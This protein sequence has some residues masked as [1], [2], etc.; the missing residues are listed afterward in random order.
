MTVMKSHAGIILLVYKLLLII[1]FYNTFS[2]GILLIL[3]G[4]N[5]SW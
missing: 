5:V 2:D 4:W 1:L 3:I